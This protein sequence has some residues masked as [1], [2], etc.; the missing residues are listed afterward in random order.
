V[1]DI[2]AEKERERKL[3]RSLARL[4][5]LFEDS[6][7]MINIHDTDGNIIT[8]NPRLC[9]KTGYDPSELAD[10]KVWELD[11]S[12]EPEDAYDI[13]ADMEVGESRRFEGHYRRREGSTFPVEIRIRRL[14]LEGEEQFIA[15]G[16]DISDHKARKKDLVQYE[17]IIENLD[18][19]ATIIEPDGT[20]MYI[21]PS[22][23]RM[24]GYD[25]DELIGQNGFQYQPASTVETMTEAIRYVIENPGESRTIQTEFKR[26]D[27]SFCWVESTLRNRLEGDVIEG[28]LVS[29][30]DITERKNRQ[31]QLQRKNER[32]D[33][34][35]S[36]VSHDLRNPL[37]VAQGRLELAR[38]D[39]ESPHLDNIAKAH[40]RIETLIEDLLTLAQQGDHVSDTGPVDLA[41]VFE[42]GWRNVE[43][44][45]A[46]VNVS[47]ERTI[48]ADRSR[49]G[50]L[51][52]NLIRNAVEHGS[53]DATVTIGELDDGFY[54]EDDGLGIPE[55]DRETVF[56]AGYSTAERG[57]GFGL[58]IVEQV[59]DAHGW[60]IRVAEGTDGGA[61]FE[62]TGVEFIA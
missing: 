29:S 58:S 59:A 53:E 43:T 52:E 23:E 10:M 33:Q 4:E 28:I 26:A 19:I 48:Q 37:N 15:I 21:S 27:G 55:D 36:V 34:F 20:I 32:L 18:D 62:F 13:W 57:T 40:E 14:D 49:L 47:V 25:S 61:R 8:P 51:L 50:Q 41:D 30:R 6:P 12:I 38:E 17:S 1:R 16:R 9:E 35:A 24:L 42:S 2:S 7:D 46:V 39:C 54:V 5:A 45:D 44:G 11:E 3:K 56:D 31:E 22:V 60:D